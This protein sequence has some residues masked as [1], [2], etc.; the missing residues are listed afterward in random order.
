MKIARE[1]D[2]QRP[3]Y[4]TLRM[5]QKWY[6]TKPFTKAAIA[7]VIHDLHEKGD[8]AIEEMHKR[9]AKELMV[10]LQK[11]EDAKKEGKAL[12]EVHRK[13]EEDQTIGYALTE[14]EILK[15]RI[16]EVPEVI[17]PVDSASP[18]WLRLADSALHTLM[19]IL[20]KAK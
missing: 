12:A 15:E 6:A 1:M 14:L 5:I 2:K 11:V 20:P 13:E 3:I 10:I 9:H 18:L 17:H 8:A 4:R 7:S 19:H 16:T